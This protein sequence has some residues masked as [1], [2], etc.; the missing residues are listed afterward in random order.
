MLN[1][2][3]KYYK[4]FSVGIVISIVGCLFLLRDGITIDNSLE[5]WF[6][7]ND[8]VYDNYIDFR[9]RYANDEVVAIYVRSGNVFSPRVIEKMVAMCSEIDSLESVKSV[10]YLASAPYISNSFFGLGVAPLI[11]SLPKNADDIELLKSKIEKVPHYK[12]ILIDKKSEGFMAFAMLYPTTDEL[13]NNNCIQQI[14]N[15]SLK[16]FNKVHFGGIP[17]INK[18]L[19][20]TAGKESRKLSVLSVL[21]V[22]AL[23]MIFLRNWRYVFISLLAVLIPV[24]WLF[25]G[26]V[27][28]GGTLNMITVIIPTI[29]LITGTATSIHIINI[30]HRFIAENPKVSPSESL[31]KAL[32][33]VFW[34][35]FFTATTTM[36]GF[37][38]LVASPIEGIQEVGILSAIGVGLVFICSFVVTPIAFLLFPS[39]RIDAEQ[40]VQL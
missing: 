40:S 16:H 25:S 20:E 14:Q 21:T 13:Y 22:F 38:S 19:N 35:C 6:V 34:P 15:I 39:K 24:V 30:C 11:L 18:S 32:K 4:L 27:Y 31:V 7:H 3:V 36:A 10:F 12:N 9:E 2:L 26:Y 5:T 33:Y 8:K 28:F 1:L 29:L 17:L 37:I 23:L